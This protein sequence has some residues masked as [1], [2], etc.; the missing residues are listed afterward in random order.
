MLCLSTASWIRLLKLH[1]N[2]KVKVIST[3]F[4]PSVALLIRVWQRKFKGWKPSCLA[5][6]KASSNLSILL[7]L[8]I[9]LCNLWNIFCV[10]VIVTMIVDLIC[11]CYKLIIHVHF[12]WINGC[13]C[14]CFS[15]KDVCINQ[16]S[17]TLYHQSLTCF[18]MCLISRDSLKCF[19]GWMFIYF[20]LRNHQM[21]S[22][23][24]FSSCGFSGISWGEFSPHPLRII[25]P[26]EC[27]DWL[28][29]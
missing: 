7:P 24:S 5:G 21:L 14:V 25:I 23:I 17:C 22:T 2:S 29:K 13:T 1:S 9:F 12:L 19:P 11:I 16:W 27:V 18:R 6:D 15:I 8:I 3:T 20:P 4:Y 26:N 28:K 10:I